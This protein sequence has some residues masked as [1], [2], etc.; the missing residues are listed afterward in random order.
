MLIYL[1][2]DYVIWLLHMIY[3][4]VLGLIPVLSNGFKL[5]I[6]HNINQFLDKLHPGI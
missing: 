5:V 2:K 1:V 3:R 4:L 6:I